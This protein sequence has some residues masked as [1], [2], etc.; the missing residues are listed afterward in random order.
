MQHVVDKMMKIL[1]DEKAT[2]GAKTQAAQALALIKIAE[3]LNGPG[4]TLGPPGWIRP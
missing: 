2:D 3:V 4:K 1:N